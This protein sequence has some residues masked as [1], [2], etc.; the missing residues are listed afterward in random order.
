MEVVLI[1]VFHPVKT[2]RGG[3]RAIFGTKPGCE[4]PEVPVFFYLIEK[5]YGTLHYGFWHKYGGKIDKR[6]FQPRACLWACVAG[7][8]Q[9]W[10]YSIRPIGRPVPGTYIRT[11]GFSHQTVSCCRLK[12]FGG[13]LQNT[14]GN[15]L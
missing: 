9:G 12:Y 10:C 14:P 15:G 11:V 5:G 2:A 8:L 13:T 4:F 7:W 1:T 6:C 3:S